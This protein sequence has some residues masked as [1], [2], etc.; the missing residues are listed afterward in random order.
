MAVLAISGMH[1]G[2][3]YSFCTP[4][5]K[6]DQVHITAFGTFLFNKSIGSLQFFDSFPSMQ[7]TGAF[8]SREKDSSELYISSFRSCIESIPSSAFITHVSF[9]SCFALIADINHNLYIIDFA[10]MAGDTREAYKLT[11]A[12]TGLNISKISVGECHALVLTR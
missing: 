3:P 10:L 4:C 6:T 9:G 8:T 2:E 12:S 7:K 11:V 5:N 1:E